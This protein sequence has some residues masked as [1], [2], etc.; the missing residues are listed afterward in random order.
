ME[1]KI[2]ARIKNGVLNLGCANGWTSENA[3]MR[4]YIRS[5]KV[6]GTTREINL[7][8]C[9]NEISYTAIIEG[10]E[11]LVKYNVYSD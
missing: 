8:N 10:E 9:H 5:F 2:K 11:I 1:D 3:P 7:G 6:E 4:D